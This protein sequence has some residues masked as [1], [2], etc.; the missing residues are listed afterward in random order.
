VLEAAIK[1]YHQGVMHCSIGKKQGSIPHVIGGIIV[2]A[3][4][5]KPEEHGVEMAELAAQ[6]VGKGVVGFDIAGEEGP[7]PLFKHQTG[8]QHAVSRGVPLTIHAGEW[9]TKWDK[10][11]EYLN[12]EPGHFDSAPNIQLA[13]DLGCQRIGHALTLHSDPLLVENVLKRNI[14]IECC[15]TSNVKRIAGYQ[16]HPIKSMIQAG[17]PVTLNTDNR[18]LN[19]TT[20]TQEVLHG[21]LDVGL[22][23]AQI[24]ATLLTAASH[25]FFWR[26]NAG[27]SAQDKQ[28]WLAAFTDKVDGIFVEHLGA[29]PA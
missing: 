23:W 12:T 24:R 14:V 4:R 29:V 2:C 7:H 16:D 20:S 26:A 11:T 22:S 13:I 28:E 9:G 21:F 18:F 5:T 15:L 1:G 10:K 25:S 6:H 27:I 8:I 17:L 3:L 19:Q